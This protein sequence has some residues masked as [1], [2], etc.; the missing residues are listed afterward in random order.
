MVSAEGPR[1]PLAVSQIN[2]TGAK[3]W[4]EEVIGLVAWDDDRPLAVRQAM[5][6]PIQNPRDVAQ[7]TV[8]TEYNTRCTAGM[9]P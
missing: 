1:S 5:W 7:P 3:T 9:S 2:K 6:A 8:H 4:D